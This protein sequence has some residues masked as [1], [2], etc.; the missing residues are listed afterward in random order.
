[1]K[2]KFDYLENVL[3]LS[4]NVFSL[5]IENKN[6]FYRC[7]RDLNFISNGDILDKFY[8]FN[9]DNSELVIAGKIMVVSDYFNFDELFKC[10]SNPFIKYIS[11][12]CNDEINNKFTTDYKKIKKDFTQLIKEVD[13]PILINDEFNLEIFIK[14]L[15]PRFL[16]DNNL[17]NNLFLCIDLEKIFKLNKILV[18]VNLKQYLN[19]DELIEFYK[20][21]LYNQVKI[22]L[23]DSQSYGPTLEYEHK[24]II[25]KNLDEIML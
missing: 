13:L 10:Y 8:C 5:E 15:K 7:V 20:Y 14:L 9:S 6:Y 22:L 3:D 11:T 21:A 24:L 18:F 1:M 16:I 2:I 12:F 17:L 25:D 4:N 23:I 19:Q